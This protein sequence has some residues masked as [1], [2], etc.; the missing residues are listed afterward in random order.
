MTNR[1]IDVADHA[2]KLSLKYEQLVISREGVADVTIP[3]EDIAVL[4][5]ASQSTVYTHAAIC[6]LAEKGA[7][8]VVC[9]AK[10]LPVAML[11][12]LPGHA[13]Q[14]KRAAAQASAKLTVKKRLWQQLVTAKIKAQ[15]NLLQQIHGDDSG[16]GAL[17]DRVRSGDTENMEA[18]AARRYWQELFKPMEFS[19]D[20]D[21]NPPN[22]L[23]NY[24]YTVLRAVA[25][26]ALAAS[27]LYAAMGL[28]HHNQYNSF[29]L[30][31]DLMEPFRPLVD[32]AVYDIVH[33]MGPD[34]LLERKTK[35]RLIYPFT[36]EYD[37]KGVQRGFFP[38]M[39]RAA[40]SLAD[41]L[42]ETLEEILL[43]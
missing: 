14:G 40:S 37:D 24:G 29:A 13:L 8:L 43:P 2:V 41:A 17:A 22:H 35:A 3:T 31:D 9:D 7:M 32:Q 23:L 6:R 38:V 11:L 28:Q 4:V 25:A 34:A 39:A 42:D 27:G 1:I 10:C 5:V 21:G 16:L 12:P 15:G 26:R 30:A 36:A 18:R 33:E 19:R 20:P